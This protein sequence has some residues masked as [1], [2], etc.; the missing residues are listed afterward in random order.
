MNLEPKTLLFD[1][2][3][4]PLQLDKHKVSGLLINT[5]HGVVFAVDNTT[6]HPVNISG[7]PLSY[8]YQFHEIHI[9]Y[10]LHDREGSEHTIDGYAFPAEVI[11]Y[12]KVIFL[13]V[14]NIYNNNDTITI[15]NYKYIQ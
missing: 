9:H 1:P 13:I 5:G 15:C 4:Q 3:L 6:L 2:N 12:D 14:I 11:Y 7:G 10:G 8:R